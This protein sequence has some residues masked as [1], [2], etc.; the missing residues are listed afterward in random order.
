MLAINIKKVGAPY[1]LDHGKATIP[2]SIV[3]EARD[4]HEAGKKPRVIHDLIEA[5]IG[6]KIS[7]NTL[8]SW[9]Y[10]RTRIYG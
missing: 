3:E 6:H 9:L 4:L 2:F 1:G 8:D 10:F 7:R 5:K